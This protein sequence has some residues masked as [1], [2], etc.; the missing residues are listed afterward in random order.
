VVIWIHRY[1]PQTEVE[2]YS[3]ANMKRGEITIHSDG[4]SRGNPGPAA[5]GFTVQDKDNTLL[6]EEGKYIGVTTNNVAE[7]SGV[8]NALEW[9]H[10]HAEPE[11]VLVILDSELVVRQ[12]SGIYKVKNENL[13]GYVLSIKSLEQKI[14][15]PVSYASVPRAQNKDADR[16]VN[17]ALD[18]QNQ[19]G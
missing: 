3:K 7:Y 11:K 12:L 4:G 15:V 2:K 1:F 8:L 5:Y 16:L 10:A 13:R 17:F 9:I 19:L 6:Y 18:R 14:A